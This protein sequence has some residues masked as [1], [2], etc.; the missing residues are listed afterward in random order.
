VSIGRHRRRNNGTLDRTARQS[1]LRTPLPCLDIVIVTWNSAA[2]I[3]A[4]LEAISAAASTKYRLQQVVV[5]DNGSTDPTCIIAGGFD[6]RLPLTID[7]ADENLGFSAGCNRGARQCTGTHILFLNPDAVLSTS[8]LDMAIPELD[9]PGVGVV[10]IALHD[11]RGEVRSASRLPTPMRMLAQSLGLD[12]ALPRLFEPHFL[13][14]TEQAHSGAVDQV[15][16]AFWLMRRDTFEM[17]SGWDESY[18]L[19]M[20]DVDFAKRLRETGLTNWLTVEARATHVGGVSSGQVLERRLAYLA[21]SKIIYSRR[22]FGIAGRLVAVFALLVVE[23]VM[24]L[25]Q[26]ILTGN[27]SQCRAVYHAFRWLWLN[28]PFPDKAQQGEIRMRTDD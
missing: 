13:S 1:T 8:A 2:T 15:M 3:D 22:H 4:C 18:F 12:R 24:R 25:L 14:A 16:G 19:Y 27:A 26:A 23:P 28:Y 11:D 10:G 7:T 17:T 20:E 5:V 9:R 21:R 6:T